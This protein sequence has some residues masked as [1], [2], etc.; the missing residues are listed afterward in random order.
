[1][2][3]GAVVDNLSYPVLGRLQH[4]LVLLPDEVPRHEGGLQGV[5]AVGVPTP[6]LAQHQEA[7]TV[8][9][10]AHLW[11]TKQQCASRKETGTRETPSTT[12][13]AAPQFA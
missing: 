11:S 9:G 12:A 7:V 10:D 5:G 3:W 8:G 13:N 4:P 2:G 1:M 6:L